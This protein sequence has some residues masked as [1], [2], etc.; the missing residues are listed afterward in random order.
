VRP[1]GRQALRIP[2]VLVHCPFQTEEKEANVPRK[3]SKRK[4]PPPSGPKGYFESKKVSAKVKNQAEP[5]LQLQLINDQARTFRMS[6]TE[7]KTLCATNRM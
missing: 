5:A 4:A 1:V 3:T 7:R 6:T 2:Y